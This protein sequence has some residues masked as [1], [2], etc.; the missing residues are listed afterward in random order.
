MDAKRGPE[1]SVDGE[2]AVIR[3]ALSSARLDAQQIDYINPHGS[4][5]MLGDEVEAEAIVACGLGGARIHATKSIIG[6]ALSAAGTVEVIATLIQ[7]RAGLLHPS[8]NLESPLRSD[9]NWVGSKPEAM[10]IETALN[11]SIGFGGV[12][13]ALC[14]RR[15]G[16]WRGA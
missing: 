11:L 16:N 1:P 12:N 2:I 5:S 10:Q 8:R 4:G 9:L 14:L 7:M 3:G 13:T 6:H 15:A